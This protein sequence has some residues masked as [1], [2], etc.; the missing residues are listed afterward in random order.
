VID[1]K[2]ISHDQPQPQLIDKKYIWFHKWCSR[3]LPSEL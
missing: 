1:P 2:V 3:C